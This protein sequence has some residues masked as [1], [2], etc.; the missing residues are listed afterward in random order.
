MAKRILIPLVLF[1]VNY[2]YVLCLAQ[3]NVP[4]IFILGDSTADVGT[5][6]FLPGSNARADFPHNGVDF[7]QSIPT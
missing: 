6:N 3:A 5:N 4:A 1:W 2:M 7:P